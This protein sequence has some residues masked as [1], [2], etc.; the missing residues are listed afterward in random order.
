M[1]E[2]H[3]GLDLS[4]D[5]RAL[6]EKKASTENLLNGAAQQ[7]GKIRKDEHIDVHG[8]DASFR[9][10]KDGALP[11]GAKPDFPRVSM[12]AYRHPVPPP[13]ATP[14]LTYDYAKALDRKRSSVA[15]NAF[16]FTV[17]LVLVVG[18]YPFVA[19]FGQVGWLIGIAAFAFVAVPLAIRY[20]RQPSAAE[21]D[22]YETRL[23]SKTRK[24]SRRKR[25]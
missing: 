23:L 15:F 6:L 2:Q 24:R 25:R 19:L 12:N 18:V 3:Y 17:A 9:E 1:R 7:T 14:T 22:A 8:D 4:H 10:M 5:D 11:R 16:R 20:A 21:I 13:S